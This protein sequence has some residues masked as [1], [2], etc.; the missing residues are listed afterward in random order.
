MFA[1]WDRTHKRQVGNCIRSIP[2]TQETASCQ[3]QRPSTSWT[4]TTTDCPKAHVGQRR[5]N[6]PT[7]YRANRGT[8]IPHREET[9]DR[10]A[11]I[12]GPR[13]AEIRLE[14]ISWS[15]CLPAAPPG[16]RSRLCSITPGR[17][18]FTVGA[19]PR[20]TCYRRSTAARRNFPTYA[21]SH[22]VRA[23]DL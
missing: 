6:N 10:S 1:G 5:T 15:V 19:R 21:W 3:A 23:K 18:T 11:A 22:D 7:N 13:G 17:P 8:A 4:S 16:H 12:S 14:R 9:A 20:A 2:P